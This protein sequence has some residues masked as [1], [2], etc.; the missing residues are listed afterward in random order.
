MQTCC[1]QLGNGT[2]FVQDDCF[3]WCDVDSPDVRRFNGCLVS[4]TNSTG[5]NDLACSPNDRYLDDGKSAGNLAYSTP[6]ATLSAL[7][8]GVLALS[9]MYV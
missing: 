3:A 1:S 2:I 4:G 5:V 8:C 9:M 6:K 7:F